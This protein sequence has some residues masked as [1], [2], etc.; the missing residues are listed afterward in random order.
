MSLYPWQ[1]YKGIV[2][3]QA[4]LVALG[5]YV[6][7]SLSFSIRLESAVCLCAYFRK[8]NY[9]TSSFPPVEI[10]RK[11]VLEIFIEFKKRF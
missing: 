5:A 10:I 6:D 4:R 11:G 3:V 7:W 9:V 2:R 8:I 1:V